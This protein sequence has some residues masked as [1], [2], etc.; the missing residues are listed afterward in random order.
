MTIKLLDCTLRDGGY[1]NNWDFEPG[2]VQKYLSAMVASGIDMV[3]IGFRLK[4]AHTFLGAFAYCTDDYLAALNIPKT[5]KLAVMINASEFVS[6]PQGGVGAVNTYFAS[7][8][9][10]SVSMVRVALR[11]HDVARVKQIALRL[12]ELGYTLAVNLMQIDALSEEEIASVAKEVASW[13]A[14]DILYFAD[15][16]G[17]LDPESTRKV[18]KV[19][20]S[21]WPGELGFHAHDNKGQAFVNSLAAAEA[22][23]T[24]LDATILG[25]G[26]G[27][28]NVRTESL[29][30]DFENRKLGT[31][32]AQ[33]LYPLVLEDFAALH[34][35]HG[36]GAN[37]FYHLS[38]VEGIHPT[39][40][41][42][43]LTSDRYAPD[44]ILSALKYLSGTEARS[45]SPDALGAAVRGAD[46]GGE[47]TWHAGGWAQGKSVLIIGAGASTAQHMGAIEQYVRRKQPLVLCLNINRAVPADLVSAYVACHESRILIEAHHYRNLGKPV[48][49]PL[50]RVPGGVQA[51][52]KDVEVLDYG[53]RL[54]DKRVEVG[55]TG[56]MLP[57]TLAAAY[58]IALATAAGAERILMTGFDGYAA[59]DPRQEEMIEVL[60]QYQRVDKA[61]QIMAITPTTYPIMQRSIYEPGL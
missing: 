53:L 16:L 32:N 22:G 5:L 21:A 3:E 58:A 7:A 20:D 33:S 31:Y 59:G 26:R 35:R 13:N 46:T 29:L 56:C 9:S 8:A 24:W 2:T 18:V 44:E 47:G 28:G 43:L 37:L 10:S 48:I 42:E 61:I 60:E 25:M 49:L 34:K 38:A 36:W 27:A 14:A 30:I 19:L 55:D 15:S 17:N 51:L 52:L 57:A 23:A 11:A 6:E 50:A 45:Y 39:Y 12:K 41:Q 40:V 1:Y 54:S 4:P